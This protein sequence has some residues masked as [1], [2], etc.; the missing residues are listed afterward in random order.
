MPPSTTKPC[1][2]IHGGAGNITR[3]NLPPEAYARYDATLRRIHRST[4]A[5]LAKGVTALDAATDAVTLF[6]DCPEFNCG[7]GAVSP[8]LEANGHGSGQQRLSRDFRSLREMELLNWR[9]R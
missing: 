5:L 7:K 6:E 1:L 3:E 4:T 2:I 8:K 9:H